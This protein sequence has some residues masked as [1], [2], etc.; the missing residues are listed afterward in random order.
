VSSMFTF[1]SPEHLFKM[2]RTIRDNKMR[3]HV[4]YPG[5]GHYAEVAK[6]QSIDHY[7]NYESKHNPGVEMSVNVPGRDFLNDGLNVMFDTG[8]LEDLELDKFWEGWI[9]SGVASPDKIGSTMST[10]LKLFLESD[11][12][13]TGK[14]GIDTRP[15]SPQVVEDK[16]SAIPLID[17]GGFVKAIT[18]KV[19]NPMDRQ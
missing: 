18:W 12:Y 5:G 19:Q 6:E 4:G 3:V 8:T 7:A 17:T 13:T 9:Q 14:Y 10:F 15:N 1:E 11:P 16:G 2:L